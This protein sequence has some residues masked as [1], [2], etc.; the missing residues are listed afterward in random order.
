[1]PNYTW[2]ALSKI[3]NVVAVGGTTLLGIW[4]VI[5]RRMVLERMAAAEGEAADTSEPDSLQEGG[6]R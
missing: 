6:T 3:P 4:W 5:R 1:M 2:A